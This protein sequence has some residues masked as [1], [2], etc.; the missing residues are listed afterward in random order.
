[1]SYLR[2]NAT[3][4]VGGIVVGNYNAQVLRRTAGHGAVAG[5]STSRLPTPRHHLP[6]VQLLHLKA[7]LL[8]Q[9]V[10]HILL[11]LFGLIMIYLGTNCRIVITVLKMF[12]SHF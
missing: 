8:D 1:M 9:N 12:C 6:T 3:L 2:E 5:V 7:H 4:M 10:K 11:S